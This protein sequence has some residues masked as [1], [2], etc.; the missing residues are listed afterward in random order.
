MAMSKMRKSVVKQQERSQA[1]KK[2]LASKPTAGATD[3]NARDNFLFSSALRSYLLTIVF[4]VLSI[5]SAGGF[6]PFDELRN[7][8]IPSGTLGGSFG[9]V[10]DLVTGLLCLAL[11]VF[12]VFAWGNALE[13]RGNVIEW[14]HL[15]VCIL[16]VVVIAAWGGLVGIG[17]FI[18]GVFAV[19]IVMWYAV[20]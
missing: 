1:S 10:F 7:V 8:G 17:V 5:L 20:H 3:A 2:P 9:I 12:L 13:V 4:F 14:K 6:W 11:F 19:L 15:I 18:F 16:V